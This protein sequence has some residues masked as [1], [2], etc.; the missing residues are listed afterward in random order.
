MTHSGSENR[1]YWQN[2]RKT[3]EALLPV[4]EQ[5]SK[6]RGPLTRAI[7]VLDAALG[8][9]V[10]YLV[11]TAAH[12]GWVIVNTG[13]IAG[14]QP[15]DPYPF[16]FLATIASVEAPFITLLVLMA[17]RRQ[18]RLD[19]LRDELSFQVALHNEREVT[20]ALRLLEAVRRHL[21]APESDPE[22]LREMLSDLDPRAL[23]QHTRQEPGQLEGHDP[24]ED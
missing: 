19:E 11:M 4:S 16:T 5:V 10:F 2:L 23:I 24:N 9:P 1:S 20:D 12:A 13:W 3:K 14:I 21:G 7:M 22:R 18:R 15:W 8:H 17:Q 6:T